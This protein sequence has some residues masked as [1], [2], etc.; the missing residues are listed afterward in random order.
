MQDL[1]LELTEP[2]EVHLGLLFGLYRSLWHADYIPWLSII[3]KLA[4]VH[5]TTLSISLMMILKTVSLSTDPWGTALITNF[6]S[7][8]EP[9][10]TPLWTQ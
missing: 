1:A 10:T 4:G 9:L 8:T 5:S 7:D 6:H 3:S 2:H